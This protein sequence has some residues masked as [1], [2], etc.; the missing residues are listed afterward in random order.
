VQIWFA[1]PEAAA[2]IASY[3]WDGALHPTPDADFLS[4]VDMNMGYNKV[5]AVLERSVDHR[6][7]WP[8]GPTAP[9]QATV[10]VTYRHPLDV[11]DE[12]CVPV[13]DF[14]TLNSYTDMIAR[15][16]FGYVRLYVPRG[17]ELIAIEGVEADSIVS[18]AGERGTQLFAGYFAMQ[19]GTEHTVTFTYTLPPTITVDSYKLV[20]QR[21]AGIGPLPLAIAVDD[22][23]FSLTLTDGRMVWPADAPT[24]TVAR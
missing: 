11:V 17:S 18:Q 15:C 6:V 3:G 4:L 9:A 1:D 13:T 23:A 20:V 10:T 22:T 8:D 2:L 19:P 21:Q 12:Q 5:N 16:Y 7:Q 24:L 14:D